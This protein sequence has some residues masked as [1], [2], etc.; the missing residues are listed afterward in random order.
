MGEIFNVGIIIGS[1]RKDSV[2]RKVANA[3]I[4]L[5]PPS[6]TFHFIDIGKLPLYNPDLEENTPKEW[7]D[8]REQIKSADALLFVTPEYNRSVPAALKNAIDIGSR[9]TGFNAWARK[10][11]GVVT[12]SPGGIGGFGANH[13]LRQT[14]VAVNVFTM[15]HPEAYIGGAYELFDEKGNLINEKTEKYLKR[16]ME[17]FEE[18][19]RKFVL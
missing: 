19:V 15:A 13:H 17:V 7:I 11:G 12:V 10:P 4:K 5:A 6:L 9:P 8:L 3:L 2:N 1:L 18:W 16:F 14:L